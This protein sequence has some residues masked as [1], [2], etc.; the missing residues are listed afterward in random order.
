MDD[1]PL[2]RRRQ[3]IGNLRAHLERLPGVRQ[4]FRELVGEILPVDV[5]HDD[6]RTP[7]GVHSGVEN[8][9]DVRMLDR[10]N[11]FGFLQQPACDGW[12]VDVARRDDLDCDLAFEQ[13]VLGENTSPIPPEPSSRTRR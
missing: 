13:Q 8:R 5:L 10:G 2:V 11:A 1:P 7:V 3:G 12:I 4:P 6:E 9:A